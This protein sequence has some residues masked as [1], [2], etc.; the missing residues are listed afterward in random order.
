MDTATEL[1]EPRLDIGG[2]NPPPSA[3]ESALI[4]LIR[5]NAWLLSRPEI[6]D[7]DTAKEAGEIVERLRTSKKTL[8]VA[9]KA[10]LAPHDQA[11]A[12]VKAQYRD[13]VS[14]IDAA[15]NDLLARS[16][17]WLTR[18]R[19][20]IAA[21]KA[22]QEAEARRLRDEADRLERERIERERLE[23]ERVEAE[24]LEAEPK[25]EAPTDTEAADLA[26]IAADTA[27]R[28]AEKAAA[29]KVAPVAIKAAGAPRAMTLRTYWSAV[30]TDEA[31][32]IESFKDHAT[33]RKAALAAALQVANELARTSKSEDA[34]P[35]GFRFIKEERAS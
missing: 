34:A 12:D 18:E 21:E 23:R 16:G 2:N 6:T 19:E 15:L 22:A 33:V 5:A 7:A 8:A 28:I 14:K 20:R 3:L 31:A 24:R 29:R 17:A 13:P 25:A 35:A 11:I 32:A 4:L 1:T 26:V 9:Q 30:V 27:A 10:E